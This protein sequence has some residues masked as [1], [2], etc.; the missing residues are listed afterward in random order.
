MRGLFCGILVVC[1]GAVSYSQDLTVRRGAE[2]LTAT[3]VDDKIWLLRMDGEEYFILQ[4]STVDTLTKRIAIKDAVIERHE[5][6]LAAQDTLL[7]KYATF[8]NAANQH[9]AVQKALIDTAETLYTGYKSL[10]NDLKKVIGLTS[11]AVTGSFGLV[12]PPGGSVRPVAAIGVSFQHWL[13]QYQ[14]GKDF[15][16][17]MVGYFRPF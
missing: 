7:G 11:F 10:Y 9:I 16:G 4:R 17:V 2:T 5:K 3:K 15:K 12:D 6:V 8:E 1:V 13:A 14:F